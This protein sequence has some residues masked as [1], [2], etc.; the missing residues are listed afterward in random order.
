VLSSGNTEDEIKEKKMLYFEQA[1]KEAWLC[2]QTG[3]IEYFDQEGKLATSAFFPDFPQ[4][5]DL[6]AYRR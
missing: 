4:K 1:A 5:V 6:D 2:N 3:D